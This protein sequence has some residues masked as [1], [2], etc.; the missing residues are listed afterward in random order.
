[1]FRV[2]LGGHK[3][4][5][6]PHDAKSGTEYINLKNFRMPLAWLIAPDREIVVVELTLFVPFPTTNVSPNRTTPLL[7]CCAQLTVVSTPDPAAPSTHATRTP[8]PPQAELVSTKV[9]LV[10]WQMHFRFGS[11]VVTT[12]T[13]TGPLSRKL[14]AMVVSR[15][16]AM[17]ARLEGN[18]VL[19]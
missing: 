11:N 13:L 19:V 8:L 10:G 5:N 9:R 18:P 15:V 17:Q 12:A 7:V 1:M 3:N 14:V 6:S 4:E 16:Q 2:R